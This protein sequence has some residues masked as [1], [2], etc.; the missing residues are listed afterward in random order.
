VLKSTGFEPWRERERAVP[1][2]H[3]AVIDRCQPVY[4]SLYARRLVT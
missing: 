4:E 2:N 1:A 3:A